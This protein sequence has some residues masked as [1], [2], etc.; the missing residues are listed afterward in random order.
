MSGFVYCFSN[1]AMPGLVKIGYTEATVDQRLAEANAPNTWVPMPFLAEFAKYVRDPL[2]KEQ[3]LHKIFHAQR[4]N[5]RREFFRVE[6]ETVRLHF[7]LMDGPW[8]SGQEDTGDADDRLLGEE[9]LRL[10]LDSHVQPASNAGVPVQWTE[11][12]YTF[13][14]WKRKHGYKHGATMKLRELLTEAYGQPTRG[15]WSTFRLAAPSDAEYCDD[16]RAY[17]R[18]SGK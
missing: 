18:P 16:D 13:Q 15:A 5:A 6:P 7:E 9:V 17:I 2:A 8:W 10:F 12:A 11:I 4:V 14:V 1:P 3:T